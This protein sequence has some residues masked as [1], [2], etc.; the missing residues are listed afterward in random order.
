M[1]SIGG[2][3]PTKR[4]STTSERRARERRYAGAYERLCNSSEAQSNPSGYANDKPPE[5]AV[6]VFRRVE[7]RVRSQASKFVSVAYAFLTH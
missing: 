6:F 3:E 7:P 1:L 4:G 2:F 5:R